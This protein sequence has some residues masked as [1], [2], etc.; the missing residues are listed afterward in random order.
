VRID[1]LGLQAFLAIAERGS[2]H[3]AA[4]HLNLSQTAL[5][6]RLRKL[7]EGLGVELLSRTTRQVTLTPA[8]LDLMPRAQR[9]M[10]DLARAVAEVAAR[11]GGGQERVTV[12]C[13][14]TI[15]QLLALRVLPAFRERHPE[16]TV[17]IHDNSAAEIAAKVKAGDA[18]FGLTILSANRW[19]LDARPL[20]S[21]PFV[22]VVPHGHALAQRETVTWEEVAGQPL[23]R[24]AAET[25]NRIL[26]DDALGE[27]RER[28][29]WRYEVQRVPTAIAIAAGGA[30]LT[31]VPRTAVTVGPIPGAVAIPLVDP[32][33]VRTVSIVTPR[34]QSPGRLAGALLA[35]I[36]ETLGD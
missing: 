16:A 14:P 31:I 32:G 36:E 2:F 30:A 28:L 12:G 19:D 15:A 18:S 1:H 29:D 11:A 35:L 21:E 34:G 25:G 3:K 13:L 22:L 20:L 4:A 33:I 23:V 17:R 5:S 6:H 26:I 8:G 7:E 9:A 27:R 10:E 24:I